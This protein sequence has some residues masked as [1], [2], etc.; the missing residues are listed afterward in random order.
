MN[1]LS[2]KK[3]EGIWYSKNCT[4]PEELLIAPLIILKAVDLPAPLVPSSPKTVPGFS[5]N[6]IPLRATL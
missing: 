3:S 5:P 4:S 1:F 6:V 2:F